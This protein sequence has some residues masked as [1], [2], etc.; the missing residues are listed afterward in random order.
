MLAAADLMSLGS[1]E[2]PWTNSGAI[3]SIS[4]NR[5]SLVEASVDGTYND[6]FFGNAESEIGYQ[7]RIRAVM[8]NLNLDFAEI[9]ARR[10]YRREITNSEDTNRV[11]RDVIPIA[12]DEFLDHIQQLMWR[13]KGREL[14]G[15][16]NPMIV[17]DLFLDQSTPWE[18][19]AQSHINKV[20]KAAK[21][22]LSLAATYIADVTTSR[23]LFQKIFEPA[24]DQLLG[25]L[26]VKTAELLTPHQKSHPITYNNY[27]TDTLQKVRSERS[28]NEFSRIVK[29]FFGVSS[30]EPSFY[31]SH[32]Q[33]DLGQ[34]VTALMQS[35]EQDSNR[36]ACS[37]ALDCM[38][39]YYKVAYLSYVL[40]RSHLNNPLADPAVCSYTLR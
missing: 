8:Q 21:E 2:L 19:I 17:A 33:K 29:N 40:F 10:G 15:T 11:S 38:E 9:I 26:S 4:V 13:T 30:L 23:A 20:W 14:S 24:L 34:L 3:Y 25:I 35:T 36:F 27:F 31:P 22:F 28:K 39:A 1:L 37:E 18:A 6:P 5:S 16:F 7:K 12:R 32:H